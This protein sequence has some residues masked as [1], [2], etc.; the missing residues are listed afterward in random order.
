M[1]PHRFQ[2]SGHLNFSMLNSAVIS[3]TFTDNIP[4]G[5]V[6][7]YARNYNILEIKNGQAALMYSA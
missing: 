7:V 6:T 3:L 5:S 1:E 2:P 4:A